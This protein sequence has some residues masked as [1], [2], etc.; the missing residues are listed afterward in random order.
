MYMDLPDTDKNNKET[1]KTIDC[2]CKMIQNK[3]TGPKN[4]FFFEKIR[5]PLLAHI[6]AQKIQKINKNE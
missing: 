2:I 1:E 5:F 4:L 3:K 6:T